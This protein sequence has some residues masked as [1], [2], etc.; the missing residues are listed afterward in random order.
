M[1]GNMNFLSLSTFK[2][3]KSLD[4][5]G[6]KWKSDQNE[7]RIPPKWLWIPFP[8][9]LWLPRREKGKLG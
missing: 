3:N 1:K 4:A 7:P 6:L 2:R 9:K 8:V 5:A